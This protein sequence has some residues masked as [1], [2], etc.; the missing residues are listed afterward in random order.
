MSTAHSSSETAFECDKCSS[1]LSTASS[2]RRH[3]AVHDETRP[4]ICPICKKDFKSSV[5]CKKH[6]QSFHSNSQ[7]DFDDDNH[8]DMSELPADDDIPD[9]ENVEVIADEGTDIIDTEMPVS[10]STVL[11]IYD[12]IS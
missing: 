4:F 2:L 7:N 3:M 8:A 12:L 1:K 5:V 9:L 10:I 11:V 6:I